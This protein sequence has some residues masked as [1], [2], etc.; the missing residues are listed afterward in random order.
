MTYISRDQM[1]DNP[2]H[3][4]VHV[5]LIHG[6]EPEDWARICRQFGHE[7]LPE[8]RS[9]ADLEL[10]KQIHAA[11]HGEGFIKPVINQDGSGAPEGGIGCIPH[12]HPDDPHGDWVYRYPIWR[13][14]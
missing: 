5:D 3:L 2:E 11:E 10:T 13:D 4:G 7:Y 1:S 12:D 9:D 14:E 8:F 6:L